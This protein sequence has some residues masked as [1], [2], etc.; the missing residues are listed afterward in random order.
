MADWPVITTEQRKAM[1][2]EALGEAK[3]FENKYARLTE[4][5]GIF[6]AIHEAQEEYGE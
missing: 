3:A 1:L 6:A 4:L 5:S 2:A